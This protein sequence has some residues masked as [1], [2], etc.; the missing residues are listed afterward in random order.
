M[1]SDP[2]APLSTADVRHLLNQWSGKGFFRIRRLGDRLAPLEVFPRPSYTVRLQT[3]YE[4]RTVAP[5][6][7]PYHGGPVDDHGAPP[8]PWDVPARRPDRFQ[9]HT[10]QRPLPHTER[11][12]TCPRCAGRARMPCNGCNGTGQVACPWCHGA[13]YRTRTETR[14][15]PDGHGN[16]VPRT[17]TVQDVCSCG[18]SGRVSCTH[19]GGAGTQQCAECAGS[20]RVK[21]FD[22]L[23]IHLSCPTLN[24]V[25]HGTGVPDDLPGAARGDVLADEQA[26]ILEC[27]TAL[28][29]AVAERVTKLLEEARPVDASRTRV[30]F[31]HLH[32]EQVNLQE[33][34]YQHGGKERRLWI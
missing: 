4:E 32:V 2:N 8:D 17:E 1:A 19:C 3:Q 10:E 31:Q 29:P 21:T 33:V 23:T 30:L 13:G 18:G 22:V 27:S 16:V 14:H 12:E 11:V 15:V 28:P 26:E 6:S 7:Q 25:L 9:E 24:A 5:A 34:Q 20:G